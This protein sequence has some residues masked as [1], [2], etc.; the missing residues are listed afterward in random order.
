MSCCKRQGDASIEKERKLELVVYR[1]LIVP[2]DDLF[3]IKS[4]NWITISY[5]LKIKSNICSLQ[6]KADNNSLGDINA[7][8]Y[9]L[10]HAIT[11]T[12]TESI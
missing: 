6:S 10:L 12:H 1:S 7:I 8:M 3:T 2:H 9:I 11:H 5:I 4:W